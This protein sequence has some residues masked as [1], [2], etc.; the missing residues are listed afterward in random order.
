MLLKTIVDDIAYQAGASNDPVM[1]RKIETDVLSAYATIVRRAVG[2][3]TGDTNR[4][5]D[6]ILVN[7]EDTQEPEVPKTSLYNKAIK[8]SVTVLPNIIVARQQDCG[9]QVTSKNGENLIYLH[10][11]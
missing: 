5:R 3:R 1:K 8:K 9:Y 4:L 10:T 6:S 2:S 11:S 7:L